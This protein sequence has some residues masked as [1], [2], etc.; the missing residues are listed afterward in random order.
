[1]C[2]AVLPEA[3][4][5]GRLRPK[6]FFFKLAVYKRVGKNCHFSVRKGLKISCKVEEIVA[7]YIKGRHVLAEMSTQLNQND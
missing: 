6:G 3:G 2:C 4:Y 5:T 7:K 1:M